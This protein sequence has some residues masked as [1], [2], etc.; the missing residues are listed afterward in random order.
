MINYVK[1][2]SCIIIIV[3]FQDFPLI[4]I[5]TLLVNHVIFGLF[6]LIVRPYRTYY[7]QILKSIA[8]TLLICLFSVMIY[9]HNLQIKMNKLDLISQS[10]IEEFLKYGWI[11]SGL[12]LGF[13]LCFLLIFLKYSDKN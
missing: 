7:D 3:A 9:T 6:T 4:Q 11:L 1:K 5:I 13:I 12:Y 10:T 2:Y 8:D